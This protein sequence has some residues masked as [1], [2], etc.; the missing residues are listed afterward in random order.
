MTLENLARRHSVRKY[1][2]RALSDSDKARLRAAITAINTHEAG[3]HFTLVTDSPEAFQGF[4]RSYGFFS[5]V[6]NYIALVIDDSAYRFMEEKA[7]YYAEML[8]MK[9]VDMG[10]ATCF[11]GGTFSRKHLDVQLRAGWKVPAV[12]TVGYP[13]DEKDGMFARLAHKVLIRKSKAPLQFYAGPEPWDKVEH[14]LPE[15]L[16]AL[17]AVALAPSA[18]NK[19]PVVIKVVTAD[20]EEISNATGIDESIRYERE[21]KQVEAESRRF[22]LSPVNSMLQPP[23]DFDC[24]YTLTAEV[25]GKDQLIDLG[26]AMWNFEQLFPGYWEWGNP[27]RFIPMKQD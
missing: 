22:L 17:K 6:R 12:V 7:G 5:G 1:S 9:C 13:S 25:P 26:I 27:A 2:S 21:F 15:L 14:K 4:G 19:Q 18:L 3:L 10:L 20:R 8:V 23:L 11:V 24:G 16:P